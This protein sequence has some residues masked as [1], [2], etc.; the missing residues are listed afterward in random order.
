MKSIWKIGKDAKL[1]YGYTFEF[2]SVFCMDFTELIYAGGAQKAW[3]MGFLSF[4]DGSEAL[5]WERPETAEC[6]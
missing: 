2:L 6:L 4:T 3:L 5:T 1:V